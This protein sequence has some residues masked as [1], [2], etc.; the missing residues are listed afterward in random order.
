MNRLNHF[1]Q[2]GVSLVELLVAMTIG[3][4]LVGAIGSVYIANKNTYRTSDSVARLQENARL[5]LR[6]IADDL[7]MAGFLGN[8]TNPELI[9]GRKG[10]ANQLSP[11]AVTSPSAVLDCADRWYIDMSSLLLIGNDQAPI[12]GATDTS[13]T[14]LNGKDLLAGTDVIG[15]KRAA[16]GP[17]PTNADGTLAAAHD[18]WTLI[19][20]DPMRGALFIGGEP[21]PA[22]FEPK[23]TTNRRWLAHL[24]FVSTT[25][26]QPH[27]RRLVLGTGPQLLDKGELVPGIQDIQIQLGIDTDGDGQPNRFVEPDQAGVAPPVAARVWVLARSETMEI[28]HDDSGN[29]YEYAAK[30]Y[31]PGDDATDNETETAAD[32]TRYRR[33][34]LGTTVSLRNL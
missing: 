17:I 19:R 30:R 13:T 27:L 6:I 10:S 22:G 3:V 18:E 29:V 24:Y 32:P 8:S 15:V 23:A 14:C 2:R 21:E 12:I 5:A 20:T 34:L 9:D 4:F 25:D 33:M 31:I 1:Q 26:G 7:Q 16:S 28:D 11:L